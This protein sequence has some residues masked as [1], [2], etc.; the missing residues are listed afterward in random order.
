MVKFIKRAKQYTH[1]V[2]DGEI[3]VGVDAQERIAKGTVSFLVLDKVTRKI[4]LVHERHND[5]STDSLWE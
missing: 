3:S 4:L 1:L 5:E 2:T